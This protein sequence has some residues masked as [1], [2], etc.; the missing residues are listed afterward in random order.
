[1]GM[2]IVLLDGAVL[3]SAIPVAVVLLTAVTA[4]TAAASTA[5]S[6]FGWC[7]VLGGLCSRKE[8]NLVST[9]F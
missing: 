9:D 8:F 7:A 3:G 5:A 6:V 4:T 2:I 1:M